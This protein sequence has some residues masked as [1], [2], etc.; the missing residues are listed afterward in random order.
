MQSSDS[1]AL[2]SRL[3][4]R[5]A[6]LRHDP[7][8]MMAMV[9]GF[10]DQIEDALRRIARF[11]LDPSIAG[12]I[13]NVLLCGMGGSGIGGDVI[14]S[15]LIPDLKA[16]F[17]ICRDF[18][19]PGYIGPDSL[20]IVSS[21]SGNTEETLRA[22]GAISS[23][24]ARVVCITSGGTLLSRARRRDIPHLVIPGGYP[25]RA[26]LG[27]SLVYVLKILHESRL[28][29]GRLDELKGILA[30]IGDR[31]GTFKPEISFSMNPAKKLAAK[32]FGKIPVI[33]SSCEFLHPVA[34]RWRCQLNENSK[35]LSFV[36]MLPEDY[37]NG[38]MGWQGE[39]GSGK[40]YIVV[41]FR[42]T[43]EEERMRNQL[44]YLKSLLTGG[45]IPFL[46]IRSEGRT[47][48][49]RMLYLIN[50]GDFISC[51]LAYLEGVDPTELKSIDSLKKII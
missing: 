16:P 49:E 24:G 35:M 50:L 10:I 41:F 7:S 14:R 26:A 18:S 4:D 28:I 2:I 40:P 13:K 42:D 6:I 11:S 36:S 34:Y 37:H 21:Y 45:D 31:T 25:P 48:M 30:N 19:V 43:G 44:F 33:Y 47:V 38:I 22:F 3:D 1:A 15:F 9:A 5:E 23:A 51:Y 8:G 20:V 17:Q 32:L 46:E 27:Y 12:S 29:D 39:V